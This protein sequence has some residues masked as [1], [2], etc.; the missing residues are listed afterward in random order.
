MKNKK[1]SQYIKDFA[2]RLQ[3]AI[4]QHKQRI[5]QLNTIDPYVKGI[6]KRIEDREK[7]V[8]K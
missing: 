1:E 4:V 5:K 8:D 6:I 7:K 3:R 2:K